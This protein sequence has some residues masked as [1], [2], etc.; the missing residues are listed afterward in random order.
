MADITKDRMTVKKASAT[1]MEQYVANAKAATIYWI[2][3]MQAVDATNRATNPSAA[4]AALKVP[5]VVKD[6]VDNSLGAND[7]K[8]VEFESGTFEFAK[9]G[10]NT[11]V[12]ANLWA[13]G[14]ASDNQTISNNAADGPLA[15]II[16]GINANSVDIKIG[17]ENF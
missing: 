13:K 1:Y 12:L 7:A 16:V 9:H 3:T 4:G 8:Q 17:P 11:P 15:G 10:V 6:R 2:G 14:Y 5:G